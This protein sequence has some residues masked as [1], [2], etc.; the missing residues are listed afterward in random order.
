MLGT[1]LD[2]AVSNVIAASLS[3]GGT[4]TSAAAKTLSR[5][6]QAV[7]AAAML[8]AG[9]TTTAHIVLSPTPMPNVTASQLSHLVG[10]ELHAT[11]DAVLWRLDKTILMHVL[12]HEHIGTLLSPF[13][14]YQQLGKS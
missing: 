5:A 3:A 9:A 12:A 10:V 13:A 8:D 14:L 7:A 11:Q 1:L 6:G 2:T 4:P